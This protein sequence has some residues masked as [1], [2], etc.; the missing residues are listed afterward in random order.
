MVLGYQKFFTPNGDGTNEYWNVIGEVAYPNYVVHI[1]DRYGK[2]IKQLSPKDR[3]WDGVFQGRSM[4]SAD[5]WFRY[6]YGDEKSVSG[7]FSLKR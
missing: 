4:P 1:Y 6:V 3:G 7:H 2:L 5:Y